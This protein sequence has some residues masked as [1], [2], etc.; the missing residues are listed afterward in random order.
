MFI[1]GKLILSQT[2][3]DDFFLIEEIV[4]EVM[5]EDEFECH[6]RV[7]NNSPELVPI[8]IVSYNPNEEIT[9]QSIEVTIIDGLSERDFVRKGDYHFV[10]YNEEK[11][12]IP[13]NKHKNKKRVLRNQKYLQLPEKKDV[14]P[15]GIHIID[16]FHNSVFT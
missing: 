1:E 11:I 10:S 9:T 7:T 2:E 6:F 12:I 15:Q 3:A 14:V 16:L 4:P 13:V 8:K 5:Y